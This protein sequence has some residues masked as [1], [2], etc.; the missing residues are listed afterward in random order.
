MIFAY[1]FK[2]SSL[3]TFCSIIS[4]WHN[5]YNISGKNYYVKIFYPPK[6]CWVQTSFWENL[7]LQNW[8]E[9]VP[10]IK[11]IQVEL[12][13]ENSYKRKVDLFF[14]KRNNISA[15]Q[16]ISDDSKSVKSTHMQF[17]AIT[18]FDCNEPYILWLPNKKCL[19]NFFH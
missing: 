2:L 9:I 7:F 3:I 13:P 10:W 5:A 19:E 11:Y 14:S 8:R 16:M 1:F 4:I 6:K 15:N 18:S 17:G 12:N